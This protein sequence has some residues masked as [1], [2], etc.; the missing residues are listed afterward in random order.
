MSDGGAAL[1]LCFLASAVPTIGAVILTVVLWAPRQPRG[2]MVDLLVAM[3]GMAVAGTLTWEAAPWVL[4]DPITG[5]PGVL[6]GVAWMITS[7]LLARGSRHFARAGIGVAGAVGLFHLA[8][9]V[10][11]VMHAPSMVD[12]QTDQVVLA[13]AY[14]VFAI[15]AGAALAVVA[16]RARR[17]APSASYVA[18]IGTSF[19]PPR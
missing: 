11:F 17:R 6:V 1:F 14:L 15:P 12:G 3:S 8:L 9:L 4:I 5:V 7:I 19:R 13:A 2:S 16:A 18:P 10:L